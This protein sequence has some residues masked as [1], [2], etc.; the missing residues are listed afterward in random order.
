MSLRPQSVYFSL[1]VSSTAS[2]GMFSSL[3]RQRNK[4]QGKLCEETAAKRFKPPSYLESTSYKLP[5]QDFSFFLKVLLA[6]VRDAGRNVTREESYPI[7][8]SLYTSMVS[9]DLNLTSWWC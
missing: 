6:I 7:A 5:S 9:W 3:P 4:T 8:I 2:G 1:L